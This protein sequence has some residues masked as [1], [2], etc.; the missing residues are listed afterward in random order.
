M[1]SLNKTIEQH[2]IKG[3]CVDFYLVRRHKVPGQLA[4]SWDDR[5]PFFAH[6]CLPS[7]R[8]GLL[9]QWRTRT[10]GPESLKCYGA[11]FFFQLKNSP[12]CRKALQAEAPGKLH[13][14]IPHLKQTDGSFPPTPQK[15]RQLRHPHPP[16][17]RSLSN[18]FWR[19]LGGS[20]W[21]AGSVDITLSLTHSLVR[22]G[23]SGEFSLL[24]G[25]PPSPEEAV[26]TYG[27]CH[28]I[29]KEEKTVTNISNI[30]PVRPLSRINYVN[31]Y[32]Y[33]L[34]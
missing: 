19:G 4:C 32:K 33:L 31:V 9:P 30:L 20:Q 1:Y 24:Q 7:P 12:L 29:Q 18:P 28:E 8:L 26:N 21:Q 5:T 34:I 2:A 22:L 15:R 25:T 14:D 6:L 17:R 3:S 11:F 27:H 23:V 16:H 13:Q 10:A